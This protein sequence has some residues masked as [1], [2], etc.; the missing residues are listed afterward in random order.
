VTGIWNVVHRR[1]VKNVNIRVE[2][3]DDLYVSLSENLEGM[4]SWTHNWGSGENK[5]VQNFG[6]RPYR[7]LP[8]I[9]RQNKRQVFKR[10]IF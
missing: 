8:V 10:G 9:G 4:M 2:R 1:R 6:G 5:C 3:C 7:N